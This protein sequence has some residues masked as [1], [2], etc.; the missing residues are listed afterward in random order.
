MFELNG[1]VYAGTSMDSVEVSKVK[2]L[3]DMIMLITF[4]SGETRLFDTSVLNG[5]VFEKL[6]N[7]DVFMNPK[8]EFGVVT[9]D[10]GSIDCSPEFM[11]EH[12]YEYRLI[13]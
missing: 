11:L 3:D 1:V 10:N 13:S 7:K 12:S 5:P 2:P 8:I 9:W 4:T 6:K